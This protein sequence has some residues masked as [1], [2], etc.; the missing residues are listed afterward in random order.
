MWQLDWSKLAEEGKPVGRHTCHIICGITVEWKSA[1]FQYLTDE[2]R[3]SYLS[4]ADNN[5]YFTS[6]LIYAA[7]NLLKLRSFIFHIFPNVQSNPT[8]CSIH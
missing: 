5:L 7:K 1:F 2:S 8:K 6:W 3:F 4:R